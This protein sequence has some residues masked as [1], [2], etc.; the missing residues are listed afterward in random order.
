[1]EES[2]IKGKIIGA[3]NA[4]FVA[5]IPK[6]DKPESFDGFRPIS[7]CNLLYKVISKIIAV[8]IKD[9]LSK[10]ITKEQFG[11]LENKQI[12]E[13]IGIAQEAL[14]SIKTKK[15]KAIDLKTRSDKSI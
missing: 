8:R 1:V 12:N 9:F 3:L 13:A 2:R 7:L 4:T 5:L 11:F 10:G 14:H 15:S 6:S